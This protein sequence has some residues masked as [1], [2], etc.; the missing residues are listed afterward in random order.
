MAKYDDAS[1]HYNGEFPAD[2]PREHGGTHI[3][4]FLKGKLQGWAG[5]LHLEDDPEA[6][7]GVIDGSRRPASCLP[8]AMAANRRGSQ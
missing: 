7:Q 1:W 4:L 2:Q 5:E 6:V 8:I 3:A